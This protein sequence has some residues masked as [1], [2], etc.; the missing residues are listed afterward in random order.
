MNYAFLKEFS[1]NLF[2]RTLLLFHISLNILLILLGAAIPVTLTK[3]QV[4]AIYLNSSGKSF[5][6]LKLPTRKIYKK[7]LAYKKACLQEKSSQKKILLTSQ[8]QIFP[9]LA[10]ETLSP[11]AYVTVWA[12]KPSGFFLLIF[13]V[14]SPSQTTAF[15]FQILNL[16]YHISSQYHQV[17]PHQ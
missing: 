6:P 12:C 7:N 9:M 13:L 14:S 2:T 4:K 8:I 1:Q 3:N 5:L 16:K 17:L 15:R 10:E 11:I